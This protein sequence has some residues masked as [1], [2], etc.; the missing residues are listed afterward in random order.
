MEINK[1]RGKRFKNGLMLFIYL[2]EGFSDKYLDLVMIP[3]LVV[4]LRKSV[5]SNAKT[6]NVVLSWLVFTIGVELVW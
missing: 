4:K 2:K 5:T 1:W 6:V 3:S